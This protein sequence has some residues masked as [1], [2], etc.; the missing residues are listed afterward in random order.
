MIRKLLYLGLLFY[1]SCAAFSQNVTFR[2]V[3]DT[4]NLL[5]GDQAK[6][7]LI[8][9]SDKKIDVKFPAVPDSIGKIEFIGKTNI[10]T[11]SQNNSYQLSQNF[12][13]T[14]FD[15]GLYSLPPFEASYKNGD[16]YVTIQS[17][18]VQLKFNTV[19][20]DTAKGFKDIKPPAEI[21][22]SLWDYIEYIIAAFV[23]LI[24]AALGYYLYR[25]FRKPK[26]LIDGFDPHIDPH[27]IALEALKQ[28]ENEK[29]W[30]KGMT[31][32][33]Y[34][35]LSDIVRTYIERRFNIIAM[36]MITTEIIES[37]SKLYLSK[38]LIS[39]LNQMLTLADLAKFAKYN[40]LPDENASS[41]NSA[42]SFVRSTALQTTSGEDKTDTIKEGA[43]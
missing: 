38:E 1:F 9:K 17:N 35:R 28:L 26:S 19:K 6:I 41:M 11:L 32:L 33:Y 37:L 22:F 10:D 36:E 20:V 23:V 7:K 13:L 29:L 42:L 43:E 21:P 15:S 2:A 39:D 25:K 40:P 4:N 12:I 3:L 14:C 5:I 16:S 34:I 27:I 18:L 30:Q 24:L 31:K 8:F